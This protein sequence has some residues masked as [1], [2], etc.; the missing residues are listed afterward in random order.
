M[1]SWTTKKGVP[2]EGWTVVPCGGGTRLIGTE[3]EV[4]ESDSR[5]CRERGAQETLKMWHRPKN[6]GVVF[7]GKH[8]D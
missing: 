2:G 8:V 7:D 1:E 6:A 5:R 4:W 3:A